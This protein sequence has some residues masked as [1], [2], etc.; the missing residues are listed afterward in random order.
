MPK[1]T[2]TAQNIEMKEIDKAWLAAA[3][4]GEGSI[5]MIKHESKVVKRGFTWRVKLS[6]SNN[7]LAFCK[8][9]QKIANMGRIYTNMRIHE[10]Y[11]NLTHMW[12]VEAKEIKQLLIQI[13]PHLIIKQKQAELVIE[14][15]NLIEQHV[16][17][18]QNDSRLQEIYATIKQFN[19]R[20]VKEVVPNESS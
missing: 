8:H 6:I 4:D 15:R 17:S 10:K 11:K 2:D 19:K 1:W 13:K 3:V 16:N 14:A 5:F 20:G 12:V 9:A 7:I 18:C